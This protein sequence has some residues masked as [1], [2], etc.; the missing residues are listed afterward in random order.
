MGGVKS[1]AAQQVGFFSNDAAN[2]F[3]D[4]ELE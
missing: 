3:T 2:T 4:M 1:T